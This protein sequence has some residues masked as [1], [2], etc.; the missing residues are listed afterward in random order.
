MLTSPYVNGSPVWVDLGTPDIDGA[1]AFYRGLF[2]WEFRPAG[3]DTGGYGM[4]QLGDRTAA[5]GMPMTAEQG[6]PS[7]S[8]YFR[9]SDADA[10][11]KSV[12]GNGGSVVVGPMDVMDIGRMA[13]LTDPGGAAFSIWQPGTNEGL[14]VVNEPGS[15]CWAELYTADEPAAY[16]FYQAVF[17]W[18]SS[19]MP[20]PDGSGTYRM[21][22]PAGQ[23]P[24]GMFGGFVTLGSDPSESGGA[25]HWQL[26]FAVTEC[27]A[28]VTAGRGLGAT[29]RVAPTDIEG[30]GRFAKLADPSGAR[31][32]ILQGVARDA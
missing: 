26:Y 5:G 31:F 19:A 6:P 29:V 13:V 32:A 4:F 28:T 27:D 8:L 16:A 17:G 21:V 9:T 25:P 23:G 24:D 18:E 30:V 12:Q 1:A 11:A 22:H 3:P 14:D 20:L 2:G 10:T 15:L 7:W